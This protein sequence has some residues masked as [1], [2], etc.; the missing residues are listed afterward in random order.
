[1]QTL[2][3]GGAVIDSKEGTFT[4]TSTVT[5]VVEA[6][7][8]AGQSFF[9]KKSLLILIFFCIFMSAN[10]RYNLCKKLF[11]SRI[12]RVRYVCFR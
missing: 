6:V 7:L 3:D 8:K 10:Q 1:M 12:I 2:G 9:L 11:L 4:T 5:G